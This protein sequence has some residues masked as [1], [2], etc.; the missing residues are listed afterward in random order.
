[1]NSYSY[2]CECGEESVI[3]SNQPAGSPEPFICRCYKTALLEVNKTP[4]NARKQQAKTFNLRKDIVAVIADI[5]DRMTVRQIFYRLVSSGYPKNEKFAERVQREVLKMREDGVLS[6][7]LIADNTRRSSIP[8]LHSNCSEMLIEAVKYYRM[9]FWKHQNKQVH[10]WLEKES[11]RGVFEDVTWDLGVTLNVA[12]GFSSVSFIY[13]IARQLKNDK[14]ET[15]IYLFSDYDPSGLI[16]SEAIENRLRQFGVNATF[17]RGGLTP[18]QIAGFN[19]KGRETKISNH[20]KDFLGE[21]C[22]LDALHPI[23]L[24]KLIRR[25]IAKHINIEDYK[26][27]LALQEREKEA[28]LEYA[29]KFRYA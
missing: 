16:V 2:T 1:M 13:E 18:Q 15:F 4:E 29:R 7:E 14:R 23:E 27:L 17:E 21:S 3:T 20:S 12:K 26:N 19:L 9:D 25:V 10:I 6:W 28:A 22:E 5:K 24:K 8:S 11:L